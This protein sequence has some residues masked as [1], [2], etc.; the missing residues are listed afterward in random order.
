MAVFAVTVS[1]TDKVLHDLNALIEA[2]GKQIPG[3]IW[4]GYTPYETTDT[5]EAIAQQGVR[6]YSKSDG[7]FFRARS[8]SYLRF[9]L[10]S[11]AGDRWATRTAR[12]A[13]CSSL[14]VADQLQDG[15]PI[16]H[17][18][19]TVWCACAVGAAI[20]PGSLPPP[21]G[22]CAPSGV[23]QSDRLQTPL[24]KLYRC[25]SIGGAWHGAYSA[26]DERHISVLKDYERIAAFKFGLLLV[27]P[28]KLKLAAI[29]Q[30]HALPMTYFGAKFFAIRSQAIVD[31]NAVLRNSVKR[32]AQAAINIVAFVQ[33]CNF[34][35]DAQALARQAAAA[36]F[37]MAARSGLLLPCNG[38]YVLHQ[39]V[40]LLSARVPG[41][42]A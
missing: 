12:A 40:I 13:I 33:A 21:I 4:Q 38:K 18:I 31:L 24:M 15:L 8:G 6:H 3:V 16:K 41:V 9:S 34:D 39:Q 36:H 42:L 1:Q 17:R 5:A 32:C 19:E 14:P 10:Q 7:T 22:H 28:L 37:D 27:L 23:M 30:L 20:F 11:L 2:T 25:V 35:R 29:E 26:N